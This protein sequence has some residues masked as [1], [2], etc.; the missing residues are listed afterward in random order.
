MVKIRV[1]PR[2]LSH[3]IIPYLGGVIGQM[4]KCLDCNYI[5]PIILIIE[6]ED[7]KKLLEMKELLKEKNS[8]KFS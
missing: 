7:Y 5:G 3:R 4:Y 2:C 1:C 8:S 6:E